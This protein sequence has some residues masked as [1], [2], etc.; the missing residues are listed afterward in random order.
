MTLDVTILGT[1][2]GEKSDE[3][4][5]QVGNA[6]CEDVEVCTSMCSTC[7]SNSDCASNE[8]CVSIRSQSKSF[9]LP[10]CG[11]TADGG[12]VCPCGGQ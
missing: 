10:Q 1:G 12:D 5:V 3:L 6:T 8:N 9:C 11:G 4:G 2:F 7:T